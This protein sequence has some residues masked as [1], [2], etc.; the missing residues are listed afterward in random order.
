MPK[1][2]LSLPEGIC[3]LDEFEHCELIHP[4]GKKCSF[5]ARQNKLYEI[6]H[7]HQK[8][9]SAF[10]TIHDQTKVESPS[11][12]KVTRFDVLFLFIPILETTIEKGKISLA[13]LD[14]PT[15]LRSIMN[16]WKEPKIFFEKFCDA[17][18]NGGEL[19]IKINHEKLIDELEKRHKKVLEVIEKNKY[20]SDKGKDAKEY[21]AALIFY[22]YLSKS[23]GIKFCKRV[24]I[25]IEQAAP[26]PPKKKKDNSGKAV[27]PTDDYSI[28]K[29]N[30]GIKSS[31]NLTT[32]EKQLK[33]ASK[34]TKNIMAF[35]TPKKK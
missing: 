35:F 24:G 6:N 1:L 3:K 31:K 9:H 13:D 25:D 17:T 7:F 15:P 28:G 8:Y 12:L 30:I 22:D 34:G 11:L 18:E 4:K 26:P 14:L 10:V 19:Y 29:E 32:K 2:L 16:S 23:N 27:V 5:F 20:L 21:H 33:A